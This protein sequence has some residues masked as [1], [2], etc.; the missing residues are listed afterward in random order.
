MRYLNIEHLQGKMM[1]S[2]ATGEQRLV[3]LSRALVKNPA[4]LILDEP[5]QGLDDDQ[6]ANYLALLENIC[7]HGEKT[8]IYVSHYATDIPACVNQL[9]RLE[10]GHVV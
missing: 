6:K 1:G 3:L 10:N 5:C 2:L 4:M 8:L 9:L 7:Q